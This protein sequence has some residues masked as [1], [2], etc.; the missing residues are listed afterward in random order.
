MMNLPEKPAIS[1]VIPFYNEGPNVDRLVQELQ[2]AMSSSPR[3]LR[4]RL[5]RLYLTKVA[6]PS[7]RPPTSN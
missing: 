6:E 2:E 3:S 5:S 7:W 4:G 1:I